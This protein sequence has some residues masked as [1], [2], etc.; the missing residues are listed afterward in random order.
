MLADYGEYTTEHSA[1]HQ[2]CL[3]T[4][5]LWPSGRSGLARLI[6]ELTAGMRESLKHS[7]CSLVLGEAGAWMTVA[8]TIVSVE[9][10]WRL[11]FLPG[12]EP[13]HERIYHGGRISAVRRQ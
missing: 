9:S 2:Q 7:L 12:G 3:P 6:T 11:A 4:D 10:G 5:P 1:C 8:S 13:Q